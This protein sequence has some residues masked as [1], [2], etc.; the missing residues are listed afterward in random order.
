MKLKQNSIIYNIRLKN[1]DID[2]DIFIK[3]RDSELM[4]IKLYW[5]RN[6]NFWDMVKLVSEKYTE[7]YPYYKSSCFEAL[8]EIKYN[9]IINALRYLNIYVDELY[10][11]YYRSFK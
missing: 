11:V 6:N 1:I 2:Y 7:I 4:E 3:I 8:R 5:L 9:I 10:P